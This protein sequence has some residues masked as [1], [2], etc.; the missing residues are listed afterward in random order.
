MNR[1]LE[2]A[3]AYIDS[4]KN[5][6]K[7]FW[8]D[9][10]KIESPSYDKTGVD[11][12][13]AYILDFCRREGLGGRIITFS[14]S[15][16]SVVIDG[17][18]E[19]HRDEGHR[20]LDQSGQS[21]QNRTVLLMA[22]MD[23]VHKVGSFPEPVVKEKDGW[24]YGPGVYDCKGGIAVAILTALALKHACG[25]HIPV[26]LFFTGDE[27]V[28]HR[29]SDGG[30]VIAKTAKEAYAVFNCE[31]APLDG[32][33]AIG[34][35]GSHVFQMVVT[36]ISA[37]SG[38]DPEKGRSAITEAAHKI[39]E[40]EKMTD[41]SGN[42][43]IVNCGLIQGGTVVNAVPDQCIVDVNVRYKS[44]EAINDTMAAIKEIAARTYIEGT[45]T[46]IVEKS[47]PHS[48]MVPNARN[49][50]LY[51]YF[52]NATKELGYEENKAYFA[53]GGSDAVIPYKLDIP[54]L[55]Q[56]GV[57]GENH[58]TPRERALIVSLEQ[59]AKMLTATIIKMNHNTGAEWR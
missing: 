7:Q 12:V 15:G 45:R 1:E 30:Q 38:N 6:L 42:G 59:R 37:H 54:V 36:G 27:E 44:D 31:S 20:S 26:K 28:G 50:W 9:I 17:N 11:R 8:I 29:Y 21:E 46:V 56:T 24:L 47:A 23:T 49:E 25:R 10:S 53:G 14:N 5:E 48:P 22:H 39:I 3:F 2:S 58:H 43:T 34:R 55:C 51:R 18:D 19:E 41:I 40:L 35:K 52:V 33:L 57:R 4:R 32:R 16:N 13:A